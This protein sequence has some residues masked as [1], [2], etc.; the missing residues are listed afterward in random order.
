MK[1]FPTPESLIEFK[2]PI[3]GLRWAR[4][5]F[6]T[7]TLVPLKHQDPRRQNLA[8]S[9]IESVTIH[10]YD[11]TLPQPRR[12]LYRAQDG[13]SPRQERLRQERREIITGI[14][15]V[16]SAIAGA[17]ILGIGIVAGFYLAS[18]NS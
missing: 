2:A 11:G 7:E 9:R 12:T 3:L 18:I 8:W 14:K 15:S 6:N 5:R 10:E 17:I 16:A 1:T 4:G 13:D